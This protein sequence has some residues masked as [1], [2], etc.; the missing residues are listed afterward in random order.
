MTTMGRK[1]ILTALVFVLVFGIA[2]LMLPTDTFAKGKP[3][4]PPTCPWCPETIVIGDVVCTLE[5]CGFDCVYSCPF[6]LP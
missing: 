4:K 3:P 2:T 1:L 5:A 6:P